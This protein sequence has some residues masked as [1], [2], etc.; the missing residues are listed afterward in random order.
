MVSTPRIYKMLQFKKFIEAIK[1]QEWDE[2][3][4]FYIKKNS[5]S[6]NGLIITLRASRKTN[7]LYI[8]AK[9]VERGRQCKNCC[10]IFATDSFTDGKRKTMHFYYVAPSS[11]INYKFIIS[12]DSNNIFANRTAHFKTLALRG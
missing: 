4:L 12:F 8:V 5:A 10:D 7:E 1:K 3:S 9:E 2:E 11:G 6:M